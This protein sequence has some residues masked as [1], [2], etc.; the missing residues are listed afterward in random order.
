MHC[1][2]KLARRGGRSR[3]EH[4]E[5][6]TKLL[7]QP[8]GTI[9]HFRDLLWIRQRRFPVGRDVLAIGEHTFTAHAQKMLFP[10]FDP[11]KILTSPLD[12]ATL[13]S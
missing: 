7:R 12:L 2:L 5:V 8:S 6:L 10:S 9:Q 13:I 1:N 11:V 3:S 4:Y